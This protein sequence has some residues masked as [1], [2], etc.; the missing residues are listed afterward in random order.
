MFI[1]ISD[2]VNCNH[3]YLHLLHLI[4]LDSFLQIYNHRIIR[5]LEDPAD[6]LSLIRDEDRLVAYRL[7]KATEKEVTIVFMHQEIEE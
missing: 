4:T 2:V 5:F 1:W 6:S 3:Q 7:P